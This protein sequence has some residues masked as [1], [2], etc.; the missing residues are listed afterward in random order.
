[1][2]EIQDTGRFGSLGPRLYGAPTLRSQRM[3]SERNAPEILSMCRDD[4]IDVALL[5][6][7]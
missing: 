6:A 5:V 4:E 7:V 3:T 2:H 1:L